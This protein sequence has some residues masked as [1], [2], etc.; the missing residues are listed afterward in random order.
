MN[1]HIRTQ[2][3]SLTPSIE[4]HVHRQLTGAL[5]PFDE[6]VLRTDVFLKDLNGP[7]SGFDKRVLIRT[8]LRGRTA[9]TIETRHQNLYAAVSRAARRTRRA[10]KRAAAKQRR[11]EKDL[12]RRLPLGTETV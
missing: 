1:T 6:R 5:H 10:V 11:L 2:G 12:L 4:D 7:K 8:Q 3:F 9:V